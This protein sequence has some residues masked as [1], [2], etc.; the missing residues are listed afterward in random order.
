MMKD[1]TE[2]LIFK[3]KNDTLILG[4]TPKSL[5]DLFTDCKKSLV[6]NNLEKTEVLYK[7][8]NNPIR[9]QMKYT[10]KPLPKKKMA[11]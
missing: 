4:S 1:D 2:C 3:Y 9:Y 6:A 11:R 10:A 5:F 8:K 7:P